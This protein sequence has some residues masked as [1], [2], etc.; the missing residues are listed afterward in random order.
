MSKSIKI[1][2]SQL[3]LTPCYELT[4][5]EARELVSIGI[6]E[7]GEIYFLCEDAGEYVIKFMQDGR[8][9]EIKTDADENGYRF[10][11]P[12][13]FPNR[14]ALLNARS[15]YD[16]KLKRGE[17]NLKF[18][19]ELGVQTGK[20]C[21][22]DGIAKII[23]QGGRL[24]VSYFGDGLFG[25][26]GGDECE[27][28]VWNETGEKLYG[29]DLSRIHDCYAINLFGGTCYAHYCSSFDFVRIKDGQATAYTPKISS[30]KPDSAAIETCE[31]E[32]SKSDY[33]F[34]SRDF[35]LDE[36]SVLFCPADN[37]KDEL[38]LF[39]FK[40]E[41][42]EFDRKISLNF[43]GADGSK[44][45]KNEGCGS[46]GNGEYLA[47]LKGAKIYKICVSELN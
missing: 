36:R 42:L 30:Y 14:W 26:F 16:E 32:F 28:A 38:F 20:I 5:K 9:R 1:K 34:A 8:L 3:N 31:L 24:Y 39:K 4:P 15:R 12:V 47:L 10:A 46:Y 6:T 11:V 13:D 18:I 22:G 19:D 41:T 2:E 44:N 43:L 25:N 37:D 35:A 7:R 40:G 33:I 29:F 17:E 45:N 27:L 23:A 21:V